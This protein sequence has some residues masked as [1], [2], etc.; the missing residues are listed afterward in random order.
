MPSDPARIPIPRKMRTVGMPNRAEARLNMMLTPR[1]MP[2]VVSRI[3]VASGSAEKA[4]DSSPAGTPTCAA[5]ITA[6][7][8]GNVRA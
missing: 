2:K 6:R 3:A 5:V 4:D 1:R 7:V 8:S